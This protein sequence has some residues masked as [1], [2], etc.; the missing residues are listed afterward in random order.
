VQR[1]QI[2]KVS[3]FRT[4][5]FSRVQLFLLRLVLFKTKSYVKHSSVFSAIKTP[6]MYLSLILLRNV[7]KK[8]YSRRQSC[9]RLYTN[10]TDPGLHRRTSRG[11][12]LRSPPSIKRSREVKDWI[13]A[14]TQ[15]AVD[16]WD[17]LTR[18]LLRRLFFLKKE[19]SGYVSIGF[20]PAHDYQIFVEFGGRRTTPITPPNNMWRL[21]RNICPSY[22]K[23]CTMV[24]VTYTKTTTA[25]SDYSVVEEP[26]ML[27]ECVKTSYSL[28]L[29]LT[30]NVI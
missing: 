22:V 21:W 9:R 6:N 19:K 29:N 13:S 24:N 12:G 11:P 10:T 18:A 17:L 20:Y 7:S 2:W 27:P 23:L 5:N 4:L 26:R 30:I 15:T 16:P 8:T 28:L 14:P 3:H 1:Q 25:Y